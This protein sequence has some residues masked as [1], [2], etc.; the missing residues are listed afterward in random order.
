MAVAFS[1]ILAATFAG[2]TSA[3]TV[4]RGLELTYRGDF[5]PVKEAPP[6]ATKRFTLNLLLAS[7]NGD[8]LQWCWR[9]S[10][11]GPGSLPWMQHFG[12]APNNNLWQ[13]AKAQPTLLYSRPDVDKL[14]FLS[15]VQFVAANKL[16]DDTEWT[17]DG[18][19]HKATLA[20]EKVAE[21]EAYRID[22]SG[23]FGR[24]RTVWVA[25]ETG[26][27]LRLEEVVFIGQGEE[28]AL[29]YELTSHR[30][31]NSALV[32][33]TESVFANML[34]L[35]NK[36]SDAA[37]DERNAMMKR[38]LPMILKLATPNT[39]LA[40]FLRSAMTETTNIRQAKGALTELQRRAVGK[41]LPKF[42]LNGF[43]DDIYKNENFKGKVVVLHFWEYQRDPIREPYGQVGYLDFLARKRRSSK[44]SDEIEVIGVCV[45]KLLESDIPRAKANA[46]KLVT[47]MNLSY[48]VMF[49]S[50]GLLSKLGDPRKVGG[51]L[52]LTVVVGVDGNVTHYH[53]GHYKIEQN[54]GL[55][56]LDT[57]IDGSLP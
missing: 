26:L 27:L 37:E 24:V 56:T 3:V 29:R 39:D 33:K 5:M 20:D 23:R 6:E 1:L 57:A 38:E 13:Q 16:K 30:K 31:E 51:E 18:L 35:R 36:V 46:K 52:P 25:R 10:E 49:D 22:V 4:E 34:A 47:F 45:S 42:S 44:R 40:S 19:L 32:T 7:P 11:D 8:E 48:P 50:T 21:H 17:A 14:V 15:P 9:L 55:Q 41:P 54:G 28:H 43:G 12:V 2:Q 53:A